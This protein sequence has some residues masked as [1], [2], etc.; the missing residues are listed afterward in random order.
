M[1]KGVK[2]TE[3]KGGKQVIRAQDVRSRIGESGVESEGVANINAR[4][5]QWMEWSGLPH[6]LKGVAEN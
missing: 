1:K 3:S 6:N 2:F 5:Y 4:A